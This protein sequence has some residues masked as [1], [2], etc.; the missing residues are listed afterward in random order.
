MGISGFRS[1]DYILASGSGGVNS[2]ALWVENTPS[3]RQDKAQMVL[4]HAIRTLHKIV[5]RRPKTP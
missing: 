4:G 1:V 2:T 5:A 3:R